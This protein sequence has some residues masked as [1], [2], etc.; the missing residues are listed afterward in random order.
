MYTADHFIEK[1]FNELPDSFRAISYT[2]YSIW[3]D[4]SKVEGDWYR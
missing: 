2:V 3:K 4:L 1:F